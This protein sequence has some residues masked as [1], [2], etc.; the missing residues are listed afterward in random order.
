[1]AKTAFTISS[2]YGGERLQK[3]CQNI[4]NA[5][6]FED[7]SLF[8]HE[9]LGDARSPR[10]F[11]SIFNSL[12]GAAFADPNCQ[13]VW[14]LNDDILPQERCLL[15][16]YETIAND[17]TIGAIYPTEGWLE[18]GEIVTL[19]PFTGKPAT[20][21]EAMEFGEPFIEQV[22]AGFA[23][24]CIRRETWEA[25]GPMEEF[26]G[27]YCED[28]DWGIRAWRAG[29][30]I[31]NHRRA[32][33]LHERGGTFVKLIADGKLEKEMPYKSADQA[34]AKWPFLWKED[35]TLILKR[36]KGWYDEAR[37]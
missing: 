5:A 16:T 27:G 20:I 24:A 8:V 22:Y 26:S 19:L 13:F 36:L 4:R 2:F 32:W 21:R 17:P 23:C 34:Q 33:F 29:W 7:Y 31:V 30:R 1:M 14:I 11:T 6:C 9:H 10:S 12:V 3:L 28:L 25:V 37:K 18:N 35:G 15:S